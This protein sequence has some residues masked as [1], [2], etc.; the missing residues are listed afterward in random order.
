VQSRNVLLFYAI[1]GV[2]IGKSR[3]HFLGWNTPL[4]VM[5]R[6]RKSSIDAR[7]QGLKK[8]ADNNN[9]NT[10]KVDDLADPD[11]MADAKR[12]SGIERK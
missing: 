5:L 11:R 9:Q 3:N 2:L 10:M 12:V 6:A 7:G 8:K 1:R 4:C